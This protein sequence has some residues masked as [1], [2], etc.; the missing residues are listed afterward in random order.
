MRG[1]VC[2]WHGVI[3]DGWSCIFLKWC[4][5]GGISHV[6]TVGSYWMG[7]VVFELASYWWNKSCFRVRLDWMDGSTFDGWSC[8]FLGWCHIRWVEDVFLWSGGILVE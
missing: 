2:L 7:R 1:A 5:I 8:V 6:F 3:M 4:H